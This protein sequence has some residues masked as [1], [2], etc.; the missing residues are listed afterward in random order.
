MEEPQNPE[1]AVMASMNLPNK[2]RETTLLPS[3]EQFGG[4]TEG[5]DGDTEGVG[6]GGDERAG[7]IN[8]YLF[9][10]I[11]TCIPVVSLVSLSCSCTV[12]NILCSYVMLCCSLICTIS[13]APPRLYSS[14]CLSLLL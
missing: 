1:C 6:G 2:A 5:A 9:I 3:N 8:T 14:S 12:T 10:Y 11:T 7:I 13:F 4:D